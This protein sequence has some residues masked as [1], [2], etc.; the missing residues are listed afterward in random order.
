MTEMTQTTTRPQVKSAEE[1]LTK[2][3]SMRS[4]ADTGSI[5]SSVSDPRL[6]LQDFTPAGLSLEWEIGAMHWHNMGLRPFVRIR[7]GETGTPDGAV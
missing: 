3:A 1:L 4:A 7:S 5:I 2:L 6:I